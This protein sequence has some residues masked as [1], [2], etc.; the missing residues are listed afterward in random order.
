MKKRKYGIILLVVLVLYLNVTLTAFAPASSIIGEIVGGLAPKPVYS[1]FDGLEKVKMANM[2]DNLSLLNDTLVE[3]EEQKEYQLDT[4]KLVSL[5]LGN[6]SVL[7][8]I[9]RKAKKIADMDIADLITITGTD[10]KKILIEMTGGIVVEDT[11]AKPT[12]QQAKEIATMVAVHSGV[13]RRD[14]R[15]VVDKIDEAVIKKQVEDDY[16]MRLAAETNAAGID[17]SGKVV[18]NEIENSTPLFIEEKQEQLAQLDKALYE[19]EMN[20]NTSLIQQ[21][22][23]NNQLQ[24]LNAQINLKV[25]NSLNL[26]N[27]RDYIELMST[28]QERL[29]KELVNLGEEQ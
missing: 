25:L 12:E 21:I 8:R 27:E 5:L 16:I 7:R 24:L 3:T 26:M 13:K 4:V 1:V 28:R 9:D 22:K 2:I 6:Q 10:I 19:A 20:D 11:R 14:A 23:I 18:K 17:E 29:E 15:A